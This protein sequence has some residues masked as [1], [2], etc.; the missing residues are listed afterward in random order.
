VSLSLIEIEIEIELA[1]PA[2]L[3]PCEKSEQK[4]D[5]D[6]A[7]QTR[8]ENGAADRRVQ[9]NFAAPGLFGRI[10]CCWRR[11]RFSWTFL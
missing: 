10:K 4:R 1:A 5:E 9:A 6:R 11:C 8:Q 7:Q 3:H 2:A